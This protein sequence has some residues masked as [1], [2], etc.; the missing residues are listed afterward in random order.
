MAAAVLED[1]GVVAGERELAETPFTA[2]LGTKPSFLEWFLARSAYE[3]GAGLVDDDGG[4][5]TI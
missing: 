1:P 2:G 3:S 4:W 5:A